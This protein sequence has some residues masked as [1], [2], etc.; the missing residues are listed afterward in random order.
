MNQRN[1][2]EQLLSKCDTDHDLYLLKNEFITL[3][4]EDMQIDTEDHGAIFK[5]TG[6]DK[7]IKLPINIILDNI[8]KRV[9]NILSNQ[10]KN[11]NSNTKMNKKEEIHSNA[12][13]ANT[14]EE[15]EMEYDTNNFNY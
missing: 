12:N 2:F 14:Q 7:K 1:N 13:L 11:C 6:Y 4:E 15:F 8:H 9:I 3:L 5:L 10:K